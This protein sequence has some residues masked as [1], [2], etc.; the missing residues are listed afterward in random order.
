MAEKKR[1]PWI[2]FPF[3]FPGERYRLWS[4][5]GSYRV[6]Q[7]PVPED[8]ARTNGGLKYAAALSNQNQPEEKSIAL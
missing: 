2:P 8:S 1:R 5:Y 3:A 7:L 6:V 4:R